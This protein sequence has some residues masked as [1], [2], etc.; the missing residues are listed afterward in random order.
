MHGLSRPGAAAGAL[1]AE[2][3]APPIVGVALTG[4]AVSAT[5]YVPRARCSWPGRRRG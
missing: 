5:G 4:V 2:Y 1:P 3:L